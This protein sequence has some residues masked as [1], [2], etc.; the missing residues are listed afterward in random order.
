ML[1]GVGWRGGKAG[2]SDWIIIGEETQVVPNRTESET[3]ILGDRLGGECMVAW[4]GV[5]ETL[6][7]LLDPWEGIAKAVVSR[8][9]GGGWFRWTSYQL[10]EKKVEKTWNPMDTELGQRAM[11]YWW[12]LS[13][14][15]GKCYSKDK[16]QGGF[17]GSQLFTCNIYS[18]KDKQQW[19]QKYSASTMYGHK[20][21]CLSSSFGYHIGFFR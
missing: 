21:M 9:K 1:V 18:W 5:T 15:K 11:N 13:K 10:K 17:P 2:H 20:Y 8:G 12:Y 14:V 16:Q 6:I 7:L 4:N 3:P 19:L